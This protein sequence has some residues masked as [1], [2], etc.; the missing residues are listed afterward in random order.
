M[1]GGDL[2]DAVGVRQGLGPGG[3]KQVRSPE[4]ISY[5]AHAHCL[6]GT[7]GSGGAD[8]GRCWAELV[9]ILEGCSRVPRGDLHAEL[10]EPGSVS[11]E[12]RQ[13]RARLRFVAALAEWV[14]MHDLHKPYALGP[15]AKD[16]PCA[17]VD[18]AHSTMERAS[19]KSCTL[20]N[21]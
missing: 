13:A 3:D 2:A 21:S 6:L 9:D 15:P 20:A 8:G 17:R 10:I 1:S 5:E 19:C 4:S 18:D 11:S 7:L 14:N 16:Q 12:A